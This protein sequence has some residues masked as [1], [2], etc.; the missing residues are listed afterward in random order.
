MAPKF[1]VDINLPNMSA[2]EQAAA[3]KALLEEHLE[4]LSATPLVVELEDATGV[5]TRPEEKEESESVKEEAPKPVA[6]P[7]AKP[8]QGNSKAINEIYAILGRDTKTGAEGIQ[9]ISGQPIVFG[10][11][12]KF[13]QAKKRFKAMLQADPA[14]A[15][16]RFFAVKFNAKMV[17]EELK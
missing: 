8:A 4:D 5:D 10:S 16:L 15:G 13:E 3:C 9:V 7:Q 11:L 1:I 14:P 6:K 12:E 17:L 2:E